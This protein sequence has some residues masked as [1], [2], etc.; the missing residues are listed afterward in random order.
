[1][2]QTHTGR[3]HTP[4][5]VA[6]LLRQIAAAISNGNSHAAA[7][8]E[9]GI[10]VQTYYRWRREHATLNQDQNKRLK[11]LEQENERLKLLVAELS[12]EKQLLQQIARGSA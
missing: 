4:E 9:F 12:L 3:R 8:S 6:N 2:P 11:E 1:M 10:T 7:C 5:Q